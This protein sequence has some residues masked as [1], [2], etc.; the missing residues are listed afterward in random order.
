MRR[1]YNGAGWASATAPGARL[2]AADIYRLREGGACGTW[3]E[4]RC[5]RPTQVRGGHLAPVLEAAEVVG[6]ALGIVARAEVLIRGLVPAREVR[7]QPAQAA[8]KA[9]RAPQKS[10]SEG[11]RAAPLVC[12]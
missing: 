10:R 9:A 11:F 6:V 7:V 3:R 12:Y 2:G 8:H 1:A 5:G 4:T